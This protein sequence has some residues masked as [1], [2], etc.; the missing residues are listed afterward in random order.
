M[1]FCLTNEVPSLQ[2]QLIVTNLIR[3]GAYNLKLFK[4]VIAEHVFDINAGEQQ[5]N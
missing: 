5:S 1:W 4:V 3:P 2:S